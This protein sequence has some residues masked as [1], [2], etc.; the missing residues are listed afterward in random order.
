MGH[1]HG[2]AAAP[3]KLG[4]L[5]RMSR[6]SGER[7]LGIRKKMKETTRKGDT[8]PP[9]STGGLLRRQG[10]GGG[11]EVDYLV[12]AEGASGVALE[13]TREESREARNNS[14]GIP[15]QSVVSHKHIH[16]IIQLR[17]QSKSGVYFSIRRMVV[18]SNLRIPSTRKTTNLCVPLPNY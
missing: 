5:A 2:R 16:E 8:P 7:R 18:V 9:P 15:S 4:P 13:A 1:Q 3:P 14:R 17:C 6:I 12:A 11:G 10:E